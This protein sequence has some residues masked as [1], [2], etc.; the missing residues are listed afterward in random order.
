MPPQLAEGHSKMPSPGLVQPAAKRPGPAVARRHAISN[1]MFGQDSFLERETTSNSSAL[2]N[3]D[4]QARDL[5]CDVAI[6]TVPTGEPHC[7]DRTRRR[8]ISEAML[9]SAWK[10]LP[11]S[12]SA[13]ASYSPAFAVACAAHDLSRWLA[14]GVCPSA[15]ST[16][17]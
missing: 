3:P 12:S 10:A 14:S 15:D 4:P 8:A 6:G 2:R 11:D 17:A 16:S 13:C 9:S 7:N 5:G 1:A